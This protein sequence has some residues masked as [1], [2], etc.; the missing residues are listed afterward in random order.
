MAIREETDTKIEM[1]LK[2][3]SPTRLQVLMVIM[4]LFSNGIFWKGMLLMLWYIFQER[5]AT[6]GDKPYFS[7]IGS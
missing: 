3:M 7:Y 4:L 2:Q 1:A 6:K 5:E